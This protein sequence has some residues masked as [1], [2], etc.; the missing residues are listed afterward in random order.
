M[1]CKYCEENKYAKIKKVKVIYEYENPEAQGYPEIVYWKRPYAVDY[2]PI[3]G[4]KIDVNNE[5]V[6]IK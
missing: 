3:C 1:N 5:T 4:R 6:V 2:C